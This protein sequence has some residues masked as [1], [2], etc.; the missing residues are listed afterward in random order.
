MGRGRSWFIGERGLFHSWRCSIKLIPLCIP[1][2]EGETTRSKGCISTELE[3]EAKLQLGPSQGKTRMIP[4]L[5]EFM[6]GFMSEVFA[7]SLTL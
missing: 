1:G 6:F 3:I 5:L 7:V 4:A 2:K